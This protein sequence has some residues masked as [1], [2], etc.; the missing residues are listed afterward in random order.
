MESLQSALNFR[1][2]NCWM[3][4]IVWKEA[5]YSLNF[6]EKYIAF[7]HFIFKGHLY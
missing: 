1:S 2:T 6:A 4:S 5:Y 3:A 7:L